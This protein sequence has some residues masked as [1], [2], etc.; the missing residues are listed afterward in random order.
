MV[1][2]VCL[3]FLSN[4][5]SRWYLQAQMINTKRQLGPSVGCII[6]LSPP[7][8]EQSVAGQNML[9]FADFTPTSKSSSRNYNIECQQVS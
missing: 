7:G 1:F 6:C 3:S 5:M 2:L 8:S 9:R 4:A